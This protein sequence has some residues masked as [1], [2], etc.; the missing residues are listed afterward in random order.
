MPSGLSWWYSRTLFGR[1]ALQA[2]ENLEQVDVEVPL[3]VDSLPLL[4]R[5]RGHMAGLG[6]ENRDRLCGSAPRSLEF[7]RWVLTWENP[8]LAWE[9]TEDCCSVSGSN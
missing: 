6:K 5:N 9:K 7:H 4:E 8:A 2:P 1:R 3:G